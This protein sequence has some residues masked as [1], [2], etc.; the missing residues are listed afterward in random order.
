M[1]YAMR[2]LRPTMASFLIEARADVNS[3]EVNHLGDMRYGP[4]DH[5]HDQQS[6]DCNSLPFN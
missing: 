4:E 3:Y 5:V 6:A 1:K 2:A